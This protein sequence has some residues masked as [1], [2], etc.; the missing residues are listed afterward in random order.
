VC[1]AV[2]DAKL[3]RSSTLR[4][5][6]DT[7]VVAS[8]N[9]RASGIL[10]HPTSLP[11]PHGN[12]DLGA[13]ARRFAD[14]LV[15]AGQ[16][17][18]QMLPVGPLGH[19]S[20]P[21]SAQSAFAG[22]PLL[23]ALPPLVASG[24]L[25]AVELSHAPLLPDSHVDY[26]AAERFRTRCLRVAFE[27]AKCEPGFLRFRSE[28]TGWLEDYALFRALKSAHAEHE[29]TRW[30]PEL[31]DR[32]PQ[33]LE[34]A[35][36]QYSA[37]IAYRAFEQWLFAEQ[38]GELRAYCAERGVQLIGD[39]PIFVAHDS[40][41]VWQH[42]ELFHLDA[43]GQPTVVAGVPPD[44]FSATGQRWGNPLY[45]WERLRETG[46]GWWVE[47]MRSTLARFDVVRLDHF[48][49]FQRC[50][51][52]PAHELTAQRGRWVAGPAD[53][54]FSIFE[55]AFGSLPLIA[56]DLGEVTDEVKALRDRFDLPG[57]KIL[58]FA[59]GNDASAPEFLPHN[60]PRRAVVY[61]GTHDN[62]TT[63]GWFH[64]LG[65]D[66]P[67]ARSDA[68]TA[69]ERSAA[70]RYLGASDG[71]EIHWDMIRMCAL[72]VANTAIFPLQ[73]VLGLGSEARMNR[74]GSSSG[75]WEWR[76]DAAAIGSEL[77]ARLRLLTDTYGRT[78]LR[79]AKGRRK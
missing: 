7:V 8:L 34:R 46:Y 30:E 21:Y 42:R 16:T 40:A 2:V 48:I 50:W 28:Q 20:S 68:Q 1:I 70:L 53:S 36:D 44:Y 38:W 79:D 27:R 74:P 29:W 10:L 60:Y 41:D 23:I 56:E 22:N 77:T 71:S 61:T 17:F 6:G 39:L 25:P 14:F 33:A 32:H 55:R 67:S 37:E 64:E 11:G 63:W 35:R 5:R 58:Q 31:R 72:S 47:R 3:L 78:P 76:F 13:E 4:T 54:L 66:D 45:R 52:I 9:E 62:D 69:R 75:N 18:W 12:G 26:A 59:F 24:Y 49:G 51:E 19:G 43:A 73:D 57:L 15:A 65:G